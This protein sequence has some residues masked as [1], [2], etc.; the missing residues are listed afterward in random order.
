MGRPSV[1]YLLSAVIVMTSGC[2]KP[3]PPGHSRISEPQ[4]FVHRFSSMPSIVVENQ[5][6]APFRLSPEER[7]AL[8]GLFEKIPKLKDLYRVR[9]RFKEIFDTARDRTTAARWVRSITQA[10]SSSTPQ[11]VKKALVDS[12]VRASNSMAAE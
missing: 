1:A 5:P 10:S 2:A 3:L 7:Q 4:G 8:E 6:A 12:R 9:L 11:T